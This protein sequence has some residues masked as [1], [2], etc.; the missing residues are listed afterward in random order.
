MRR[1]L[2]ALLT[3]AILVSPGMTSG[4]AE[5]PPDRWVRLTTPH[6]ELFTTA[7]EKAA[8]DAI[9]HFEQV[10]A[11][12]DKASPVR[13]PSE[14]PVRIIVFKNRE[15]YSTYAPNAISVAYYTSGLKRDYIVMSD[16]SSESYT[17]AV[18]EYFH[19]IIRRSGLKIPVWLNEGLADVYSTLRPVRDGVAVGDLIPGRM[20][21]LEGPWMTFE[22][23]AS[24]DTRSSAY[25]EAER[26]GVFYAESWALSHMLFLAPEYSPHFAKFVTALNR[27]KST[28]ETCEEAFGRSP[29]QVLD[30]LRNYFGRK[31]IYGTVFRTTLGKSEAAPQISML[32]E[33][34]SRL[35]LAELLVSIGKLDDAKR[36]YERL[37]RE[38]P[39]RT[40]LTESLGYLALR[41]NDVQGA[42]QSFEKAFAGGETDPQMCFR[43]ALMERDA[44]QPEEKIVAPLK[45]AIESKPDYTDA[46]LELG[47]VRVRARR[48][49]S[50]IATLMSIPNVTPAHAPPL[51]AA[52]AYAYL[53]TGDAAEARKHAE[54]A[55]KW[56]RNEGEAHGVDEL[57]GLI[58]ARA[59]SAFPPHPGEKIQQVEGMVKGV[60]C[61]RTGSLLHLTADEKALLFDLPDPKAVEFTDSH[62]SGGLKLACGPQQPFRV[63]LDYVPEGPTERGSAGVVRRIEYQRISATPR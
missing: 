33:F 42:R 6:F 20:K 49:E 30:D 57:L 13:F 44:M 14:F 43:L 53:Q 56:A 1:A 40:D 4:G 24:V 34:G 45:R 26:A 10:R 28:G 7:G 25:N 36:D 29:E 59:K 8:R 55:K 47:L 17:I 61:A 39:N 2:L 12:F 50:A 5:N 37:E 9:L 52:L 46:L 3:L 51:F 48:F 31:K 63:V 16:A 15:Q 21:A 35:M 23:L 19:L 62:G 58:D 27:G 22:S 54:T 60:E 32:P 18:H 38:Q 41:A 11:F